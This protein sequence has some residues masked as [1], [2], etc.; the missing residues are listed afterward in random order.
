MTAA[1][2]RS[3]F[4][5]WCY[6]SNTF[7]HSLCDTEFQSR[8]LIT[9]TAPV[10]MEISASGRFAVTFRDACYWKGEDDGAFFLLVTSASETCRRK[11]KVERIPECTGGKMVKHQRQFVAL[12]QMRTF[13]FSGRASIHILTQVKVE[14]PHRKNTPLQVLHQNITLV[15][16]HIISKMYLVLVL[17]AIIYLLYIILL[18]YHH[19]CIKVEGYSCRWSRSSKLNCFMSI[20]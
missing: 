5:R 9:E 1:G 10:W 18:D 6:C 12:K 16:V 13:T 20:F 19:W 17:S 14:I 3:E 8:C 11:H 2:V 4:T 15:K 7:F